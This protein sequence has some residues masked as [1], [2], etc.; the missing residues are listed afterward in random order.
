MFTRTVMGWTAVLAVFWVGLAGAINPQVV[1]IGIL[2]SWLVVLANRRSL[3]SLE[4]CPGLNLRGMLL[5]AQYGLCFLAELV[6]SNIAVARLVLSPRMEI[7]PR[8]VRLPGRLRTELARVILCNSITLTPGTLTVDMDERAFAVHA[9]TEQAA[10]G[11]RDWI[12]E[13][14]L[15]RIE[16]TDVSRERG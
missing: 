13:Q 12:M 15:L 6:K 2:G 3:L 1:V 14:L 16:G 7:T 4:E 8:I 5:W 11:A 10:L 9:I